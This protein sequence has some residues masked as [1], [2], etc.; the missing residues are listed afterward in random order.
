MFN[1]EDM[2]NA[3]FRAAEALHDEIGRRIEKI[4]GK[5][6]LFFDEIQEVA[7][8]EKCVN[9]CRVNFDCDI[10]V[11]GSN[12]KLLSGE[13]ATYLAGRFV[14]FVIYPFSFAEFSEAYS[15]A[16][17]NTANDELFTRYL[18]L[19]G[20]P[21]LGNLRYDEEPS[22]QYLQDVYNSIV[23][24]DIAKRNKVRDVDLLESIIAYVF[25]NA[26]TT[27]SASAISKY[28]KSESRAVA[29]ETILNYLKYCEEAF[30]FYSV[31]RQDLQAKQ[32]KKLLKINEKYYVADHGIRNLFL[33]ATQETSISLLKTSYA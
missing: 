6:Y 13:L 22:R 9:S 30:L 28:F 12:A 23:L 15:K 2:N 25:S 1:F 19:G 3:R 11:T 26:A 10:Y 33:A 21:Y 32:G 14:E 8:W 18:V 20:M 7:D 27:F 4:D 5:A 17:P 24:K 16:F 29:P 31:R